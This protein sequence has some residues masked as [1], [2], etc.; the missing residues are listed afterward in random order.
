MLFRSRSFL[1]PDTND[2]F[3][4]DTLADF[5][6]TLAPLGSI[7]NITRPA[8]HLRGGMTGSTYRVTYS[9]G[10]TITISIYTYPDGKIEQFLITGKS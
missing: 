5:K 4:A 3:N 10:T 7:T 2:Y 6:S 1:T 9:G 8:T